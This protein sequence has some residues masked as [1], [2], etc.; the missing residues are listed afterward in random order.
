MLFS[1]RGRDKTGDFFLGE[2]RERRFVGSL[3]GF[4]E[5]IACGFSKGILLELGNRV[6]QQLGLWLGSDAHRRL[7]RRWE[8]CTMCIT[9]LGKS[10]GDWVWGKREKKRSEE[11]TTFKLI[12]ICSRTSKEQTSKQNRIFH[13]F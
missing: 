7:G 4:L 12:L 6:Q 3:F 13:H 9:T 1:Y 10:L 5:S 2:Q 8:D 11:S